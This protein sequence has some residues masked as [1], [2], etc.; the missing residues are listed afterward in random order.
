MYA[1]VNLPCKEQYRSYREEVYNITQH[2]AISW[3]CCS[4]CLEH[5]G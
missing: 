5:S 1:Y 4:R 3:L 2:S